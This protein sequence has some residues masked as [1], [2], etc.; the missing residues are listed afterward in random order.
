MT[1]DLTLTRSGELDVT[2][3]EGNTD[4]GVEFV[5]RWMP[6]TVGAEMTVVDAG[7]IIIRGDE[8]TLEKLARQEGLTVEHDIVEAERGRGD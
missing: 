1:A 4:P 8:E 2:Q 3:V 6:M 5:D 7:R